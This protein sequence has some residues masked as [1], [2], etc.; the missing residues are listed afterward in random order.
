MGDATDPPELADTVREWSASPEKAY[1]GNAQGES[2]LRKGEHHH[3]NRVTGLHRP[4][5]RG[6]VRDRKFEKKSEA[7]AFAGTRF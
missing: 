2:C 7:T 4:F 5:S 3:A 6:G 1:Y